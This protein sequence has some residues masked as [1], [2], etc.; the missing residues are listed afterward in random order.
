MERF[1]EQLIRSCMFNNFPQVHNRNLIAE[2][3]DNAQIMTDKEKRNTRRFL[4]ILEDVE[5]LS[6][7]GN[8]ERRERLISHK[9]FRRN[10]KRSRYADPLPL[11]PAEFVWITVEHIMSNP[12]AFQQM[13]NLVFELSASHDVMNQ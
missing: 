10:G 7:D 9:Q 6:L 4:K 12:H 8:I 11:P 3:L 13:N 5:D 2:I 1:C